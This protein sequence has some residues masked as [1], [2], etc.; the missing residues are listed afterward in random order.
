MAGGLLPGLSKHVR[1]RLRCALSSGCALA[2]GRGLVRR[3]FGAFDSH[4]T[5]WT[6][7]EQAPACG[8]PPWGRTR[9][10]ADSRNETARR[11]AVGRRRL[12]SRACVQSRS[13]S[14]GCS[15]R[16]RGHLCRPRNEP[17]RRHNHYYQQSGDGNGN[18]TLSGS[19]GEDEAPS[20]S[21]AFA[22]LVVFARVVLLSVRL[23]SCNY[24]GLEADRSCR[25]TGREVYSRSAWRRDNL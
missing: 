21:V 24:V 14:L 10:V 6:K 15:A 8:C 18:A 12:D 22:V 4:L 2:A 13:D 1:E 20:E 9:T 3:C 19:G 17:G 25:P 23:Y 5:L 11:G 7:T 16:L